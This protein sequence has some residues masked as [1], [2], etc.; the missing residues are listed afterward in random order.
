M[1]ANETP[2]TIQH[3]VKCLGVLAE[4]LARINDD[5]GI[6]E[7][8]GNHHVANINK[9]KNILLKEL[10]EDVFGY[11]D[12]RKHSSFGNISRNIIYLESRSK[13]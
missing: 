12:K 2:E 11:V 8:S 9:D 1:G 13:H 7:Y 3:A 6:R 4:L 10:L 5:L